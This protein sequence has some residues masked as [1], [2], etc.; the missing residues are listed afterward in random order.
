M[1]RQEHNQMSEP[2]RNLDSLPLWLARSVGNDAEADTI[3]TTI[4]IS[5]YV[6]HRLLSPLKGIVSFIDGT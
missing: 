2:Q 4:A 3:E 6:V 1:Q 5:L